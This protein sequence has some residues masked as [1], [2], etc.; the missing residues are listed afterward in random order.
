[1]LGIILGG[2]AYIVVQNTYLRNSGPFEQM[3][4]TTNETFRSSPSQMTSYAS[5]MSTSSR[6][7]SMPPARYLQQLALNFKQSFSSL[8]YNVTAVAQNDSFGYGPSYLLDGLSDKGNWY[9]VGVIWNPS[10]PTEVGFTPGFYL[11][12]QIW[13]ST[14]G[15]SIFPKTGQAETYN[16]SGQVRTG[17]IVLLS[18]NFSN[19]SESKTGIVNMSAYDWNS[20]ARS[21]AN[22]TSFG[23]STFVQSLPSGSYPSG[24]LTEWYLAEPN[25]CL[26]NKV[27]YSN[28]LK[29][30]QSADMC[31]AELNVTNVNSSSNAYSYQYATIFQGCSSVSYSSNSNSLQSYSLNGITI[32]SDAYVFITY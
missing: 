14:N 7:D 4:G 26:P 28:Y 1:M 3:C 18:L 20:T 5:K 32:F 6:T 22:Y 21:S 30:I 27:V 2:L 11:V 24:L 19:A 25:F 29:P 15:T 13:S 8:A 9:Q 10:N 31:I 12:V 16:F 23:A 17:D